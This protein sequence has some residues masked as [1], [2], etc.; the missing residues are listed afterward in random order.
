VV[1]HTCGNLIQLT[2]GVVSTPLEAAHIER[3]RPRFKT[4]GEQFH[5]LDARASA[6]LHVSSARFSMRPF[7]PRVLLHDVRG[8]MNSRAIESPLPSAPRRVRRRT[9]KGS[10]AERPAVSTRTMRPHRRPSRAC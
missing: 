8:Q 3:L 10:A 5:P 1:A 9:L 2:T 4:P 6:A 7:R